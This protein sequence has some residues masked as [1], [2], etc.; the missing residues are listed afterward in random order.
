MHVFST[1]MSVKSFDKKSLLQE[2]ILMQQK[3]VD[4]AHKAMKDAQESANEGEGGMEEKF[5]SF[6]EQMHQDRDMFARQLDEAVSSLALL[7]KVDVNKEVTSVSFGAV[8]VTEHQKFFVNISLGQLV[9]NG[10]T[11]FAISP[12]T[13]IYQAMAGKKVG[14]TFDFRDRKVKILELF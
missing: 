14:E 5:E 10:E 1:D 2:C 8:V 3:I 6:R 9:F 7:K 13:P 12:Q 11:I 4:N